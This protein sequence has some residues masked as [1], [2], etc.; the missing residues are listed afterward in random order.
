MHKKTVEKGTSLK[1]R[2]VWQ[3]NPDGV[4]IYLG[5]EALE[6]GPLMMFVRST[7]TDH[8]YAD[9]A[10]IP[11]TDIVDEND[12]AIYISQT[13]RVE[14][15]K[16]APQPSRKDKHRV[17]EAQASLFDV[18][19]YVVVESKEDKTGYEEKSE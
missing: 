18:S 6:R 14:F 13:A 4:A 1:G 10:S 2:N 9:L 19:E 15:N 7:R 12:H 11:V 5:R 8:N 16:K 3:V 17:P